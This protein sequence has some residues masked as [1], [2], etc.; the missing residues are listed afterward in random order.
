MGGQLPLFFAQAQK[1][2]VDI[3]GYLKE[4]HLSYAAS[5][6]RVDLYCF[7]SYIWLLD[8]DLRAYIML[9]KL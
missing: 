6:S 5:V 9:I 4:E 3:I 1:P 7:K 8:E 2:S